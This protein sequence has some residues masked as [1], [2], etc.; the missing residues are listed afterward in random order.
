MDEK[1]EGQKRSKMV[2]QN[3]GIHMYRD[4]DEI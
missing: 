4:C 1:A 2:T 3:G